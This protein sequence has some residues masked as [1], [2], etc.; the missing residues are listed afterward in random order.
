MNEGKPMTVGELKNWH[1][2][3]IRRD[4][5]LRLMNTGFFIPPNSKTIKVSRKIYGQRAKILII[6][7]PH[8]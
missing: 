2:K 5:W 8:S 1:N 6:D 3:Q 4:V 7:D